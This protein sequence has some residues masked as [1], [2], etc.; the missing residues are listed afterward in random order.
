MSPAAIS[1]CYLCESRS[2]AAVEGQV[3]DKPELGIKRCGDCGL[4]FLDSHAHIADDYYDQSYTEANHPEDWQRF[5]NECRTDDERRARELAPLVTNKSFLD[6]GC[7]G[8]GLLLA[9]RGRAARL[10]GVDPQTRWRRRL[11][12]AGLT[13]HKSVDELPADARFDVIGLFH[14]LEHMK[15]PASFVRALLGRLA[16]G[17][18]LIVEVPSADDALLSLYRSV[19]FSRFTYWSPHL[20]LFNATTLR[21]LFAKAG[22]EVQSVRQVQRYP[23]SNHLHWLSEGKPGGHER[24][25]FLDSPELTAAYEAKLA[26]LGLT[27]TLLASVGAP[28]R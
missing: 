11:E 14:V 23:L 27:D 3:R 6:V 16:P 22:A 18:R 19:P 2:L 20:F 7:G 9:L 17:G 13:V 5:L 25:S 8:G 10:A 21:R 26:S 28:G 4:V 1:R 12:E 24:W 15:D